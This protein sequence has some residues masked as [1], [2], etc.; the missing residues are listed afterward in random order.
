MPPLAKKY[1]QE[2][3]DAAAD[4][5]KSVAKMNK[6]MNNGITLQVYLAMGGKH[7]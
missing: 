3:H 7:D 6:V 5:Q 2:T 1:R 4:A